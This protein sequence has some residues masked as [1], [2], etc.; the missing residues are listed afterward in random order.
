MVLGSANVN[1]RSLLG[2]RDMEAGVYMRHPKIVHQ[3][4]NELFDYWLTSDG[5]RRSQDLDVFNQWRSRTKLDTD[6]LLSTFGI[7]AHKCPPF[8]LT[9]DVDHKLIR[10]VV[11][12]DLSL[13][14]PM[15]FGDPIDFCKQKISFSQKMF[16]EKLPSVAF[17]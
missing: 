1:D 5:H 13:H 10:N 4:R 6:F 11:L 15:T 3:F 16:F 2:N 14:S 12:Y 17:D 8:E 7:V 9:T